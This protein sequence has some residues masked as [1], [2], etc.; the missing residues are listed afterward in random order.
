M[1]HTSGAAR[2]SLAR[3]CSLCPSLVEQ[4]GGPE[5]VNY[6]ASQENRCITVAQRK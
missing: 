1:S 4:P 3:L 2:W 5:K 6:I